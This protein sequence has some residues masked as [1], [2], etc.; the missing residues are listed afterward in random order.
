MININLFFILVFTALLMILFLFH[1]LDIKE[2]N[3]D[4]VPLLD[5]DTFVMYELNKDGL[6]TL[7]TG[8]KALRYTD[9]YV[10]DFIDFT[11]NSKEYIS[12]MKA[13]TGL[14]KNDIVTLNGDITY[15]REDGL[16]FDTQKMIYNMKTAVATTD[17]DFLAYREKNNMRGTSMIYD[18][19]NDRISIKNV[20]VKYQDTRE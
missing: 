2:Q 9:R 17:V 6:Q 19:L 16:A 20:I 12:N 11:D 1:P 4:D 7:M 8:E 5:I 13:N 18:S 3:S 15:I 14:Y 10:V